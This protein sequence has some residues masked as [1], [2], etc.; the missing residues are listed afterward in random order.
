MKRWGWSVVV[1][2]LGWMAPAVRAEAPVGTI[3]SYGGEQVPEGW[4]PCDGR[5]LARAD[6]PELFA[7]IGTAFGTGPEDATF[8]VPDLRGRFVRG[9]AGEANRDPERD[10][11]PASAPGGNPGNRV[12]S[13]QE[14]AT[15]LPANPFRTSVTGKHAHAY[16]DFYWY[17]SGNVPEYGTPRGDGSGRRAEDSRTSDEAGAHRHDVTA[18][19]DA[20]TRPVNLY[21]HFLIKA[22]PG[23]GGGGVGAETDPWWAA[24]SNQYYAK[25]ETDAR[26]APV[27]HTHVGSDITGGQIPDQVLGPNISRFGYSVDTTE[28]EDG[29]VLLVDLN[30]EGAREGDVIRWNGTAWTPYA[31][32]GGPRDAWQVNGNTGQVA[33]T[34]FLGTRDAVP[35]E[36]RVANTTVWQAVPGPIPSLVGGVSNRLQ[37]GNQFPHGVIMGGGFNNVARGRFAALL[38]GTENEANGEHTTV[39]GG[40]RNLAIGPQSVVVGGYFNQARSG[41]SFVGGGLANVVAGDQSAIA[42]GMQNGIR[43]RAPNSFIGGGYGN[44]IETGSTGSVI[45][46]GEFQTVGPTSVYA[47]ILGGQRNQVMARA[48]YAS[49]GGGWGN[50]VYPDADYGVIGGGSNNMVQARNAV[51]A[52]GAANQANA[53]HAA[54]GG[55]QGNQVTGDWSVVPG[56][57]RNEAIGRYSLAAGYRGRAI[58][59]GSFV[60]SD[61]SSGEGFF[62]A[63]PNEFAVRAGG[64]VRLVTGVNAQGQPASGAALA[65]G[66]GSWTMLSAREAKENE[67]AVDPAHILDR[68]AALPIRTW[69][70]KQQDATIRHI[71]PYA[72]DFHAAFGVGDRPDGITAVDADGVALAAIQ[73]LRA[74]N[75]ALQQRL[76]DLEA[77]LDGLLAQP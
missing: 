5:A 48:D 56:G 1:C 52:G 7:V 59:E 75:R 38:G 39:G 13:V 31:D 67:Q 61:A 41:N 71:G 21:L 43:E 53:P 72:E 42:G 51:I 62:S 19:G 77:R 57:F 46:V 47:S 18:G 8:Q 60:W 3:V 15:A 66:S 45:V 29:S 58:G 6:Y 32:A 69:N 20:E 12:G 11:R 14:A 70:Y 37:A 10:Q 40:S 63:Q 16:G 35:M 73:A 74:E 65:A 25:S 27:T 76:Q 68:V 64:G 2:L 34:H 26:Y 36:I 24:A 22:R 33:G 49:V 23:S 50:L 30:R 44:T 54:V 17:D 9:V 55:G 4:L 28:I